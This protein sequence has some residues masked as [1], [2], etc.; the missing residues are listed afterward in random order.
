[1][2]LY[3]K[4]QI[5]TSELS[6]LDGALGLTLV[7]EDKVLE[8]GKKLRSFIDERRV[9]FKA[10][11]PKRRL[12][13]VLAFDE[14]HGLM[15]V[16]ETRDWSLYSELRRCMSE[17]ID[18]PIFTLFLSTA[19][20]FHLFSLPRSEDYS[21]RIVLGDN[22]VLPP[23][24]ETGF[25]QF[26][27]N[28]KEGEI[29]LDRVMEDD[30]IF[31]LGRPL[32]VFRARAWT[33]VGLLSRFAC[34]LAS[35]REGYF[36]QSAI[37]PFAIQKLLGGVNDLGDASFPNYLDRSLA[38][39]SVRV[40][41]EFN[42]SH[43]NARHIVAK[44]VERHMRLCT[45]TTSGFEVLLTTT[46][47]EPLL[48]E[49]AF[50]VVKKSTNSPIYHLSIHMDSNCIIYG[51]RGELVAA[52]LVMQARD[53]VAEASK[54]RWVSVA[55]FMKKLLGDSIDSALPFF[56]RDG[57]EQKALANAFEHSR[58]WFNHILKI[59]NMDLINVRY[60]WRFITRGAMILCANNQRGVDLVV[61]ICYSGNVLSRPTVRRYSFR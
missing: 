7:T 12:L 15:D 1:M 61:P 19:G 28:A 32:Y 50:E 39:L 52:L 16:P 56:A 21:T 53:A 6:G 31:R 26:A 10:S 41:L 2:T 3:L 23:I 9:L 22:W 45:I 36:N 37:M 34:Y 58:I 33:H 57:E 27:L 13:L 40:P 42:F 55:D 46:G 35:N 60:L 4:S 5:S 59:Q 18:L 8:A 14:A 24:T 48:A 38:C 25:D 43:S 29:T 51:E 54:S 11:K 17:I 44:Q 47:S 30:W 49:A 20:K